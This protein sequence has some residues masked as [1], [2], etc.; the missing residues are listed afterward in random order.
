MNFHN[1]FWKDQ[2]YK[3][4]VFGFCFWFV[5]VFVFS[6]LQM[7]LLWAKLKCRAVAKPSEVATLLL[8]HSMEMARGRW[9]PGSM[10]R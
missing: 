2:G 7:F 8:V 3:M 10:P 5:F 9:L 4:Q 1:T 6:K